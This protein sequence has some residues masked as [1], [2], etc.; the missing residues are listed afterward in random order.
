M[1]FL[2]VTLTKTGLT[3]KI[4]QISENSDLIHDT[5]EGHVGMPSSTRDKIINNL[6]PEACLNQVLFS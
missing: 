4:R 5:S 6:H 2:N 3:A 1:E